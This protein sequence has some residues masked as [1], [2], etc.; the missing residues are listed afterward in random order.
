MDI[1]NRDRTS[2]FDGDPETN[3]IALLYDLAAKVPG[4]RNVAGRHGPALC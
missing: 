1:Q 2:V 4:S 3:L